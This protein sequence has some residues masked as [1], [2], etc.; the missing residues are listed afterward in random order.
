MEHDGLFVLLEA[1]SALSTAR[2][3]LEDIPTMLECVHCI[4]EVMN[5]ESGMTFLIRNKTDA[6]MRQFVTGKTRQGLT[7]VLKL[8]ERI[9]TRKSQGSVEK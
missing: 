6:S 9:P 7:F 5:S 4:R 3:K 2:M 1:L 8:V